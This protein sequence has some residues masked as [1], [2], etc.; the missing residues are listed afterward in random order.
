MAVIKVTSPRPELPPVIKINS[1]I[2][3]VKNV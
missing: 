1:K 3:K 2:F